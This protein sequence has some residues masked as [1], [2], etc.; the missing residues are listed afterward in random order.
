MYSE[1]NPPRP[2]FL[3][4]EGGGVLVIPCFRTHFE[5]NAL[6]NFMKVFESTGRYSFKRVPSQLPENLW[7]EKRDPRDPFSGKKKTLFLD[8]ILGM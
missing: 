3:G 6:E 1:T 8:V 7:P 4:S 5:K 2:I